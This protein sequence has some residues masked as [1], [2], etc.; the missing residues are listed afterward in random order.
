MS[1]L[2]YIDYVLSSVFSVNLF[3]TANL[4][5]VIQNVIHTAL[6]GIVIVPRFG[7]AAVPF[8]TRAPLARDNLVRDVGDSFLLITIV[9]YNTFK[10][11][12]L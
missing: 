1:I 9:Y 3:L 12:T 8:Q 5:A 11:N 2:Y 4:F 6:N 10:E 7:Y